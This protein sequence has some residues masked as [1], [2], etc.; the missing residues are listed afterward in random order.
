MTDKRQNYAPTSYNI[1]ANPAGADGRTQRPRAA[2]R[3]AA[4]K[5]LRLVAETSW[6]TTGD[7]DAAVLA[8]RKRLLSILAAEKVADRLDLSLNLEACIH[9]GTS[10]AAVHVRLGQ[11]A[12]EIQ[13]TAEEIA[14]AGVFFA[15]RGRV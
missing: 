4:R 11:L 2:V 14:A 5:G 12:S 9:Q 10:V 1:F 8:E 7:V 6:A 15:H 3:R 13:K